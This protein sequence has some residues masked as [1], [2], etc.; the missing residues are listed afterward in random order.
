M[1]KRFAHETMIIGMFSQ[2]PPTSQSDKQRYIIALKR[3]KSRQFSNFVYPPGID[4][5]PDLLSPKGWVEK[6]YF[7]DE[8]LMNIYS[9]K[10]TALIRNILNNYHGKHMVFTFFKTKSGVNILKAMFDMCGLPSAVFSGDLSDKK[11]RELLKKF[12]DPKN[13]YGKNIKVI[14]VTD[15]G[16]E[17]ITLKETRHLHIL[18]SDPREGKIQQAIGRAVRFKS[19]TS[20]PE[21][22]RN[23]NIWRY[24]SMSSNPDK[25]TI[26]ERLFLEGQIKMNTTNSFIELLQ[27][28]SI[29]NYA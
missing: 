26:D 21:N 18:E 20:M 24:W 11:R 2:N 15:A 16:A 8:Q 22:E 3:I 27:E 9:S 12:N 4:K 10:F 25:I 13:R 5:Q 28:A 6:S 17:G 14:F 19:H 29:E 7:A 23:V 1:T